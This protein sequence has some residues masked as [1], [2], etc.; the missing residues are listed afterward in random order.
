[1]TLQEADD[2]VAAC[3]WTPS[4]EEEGASFIVFAQRGRRFFL[5]SLD[6]R[7]VI[8][9]S[10][11]P[12]LD[13]PV[14][15][16]DAGDNQQYT[17]V[18]SVLA[19]VVILCCGQTRGLRCFFT[20]PPGDAGSFTQSI[21][22]TPASWSCARCVR[23]SVTPPTAG[24]AAGATSSLLSQPRLWEERFWCYCFLTA[25][26][27]VYCWTATFMF[28]ASWHPFFFS[29]LILF[30]SPGA[31]TPEGMPHVSS[32][33]MWNVRVNG[34]EVVSVLWVGSKSRAAMGPR[35]V[36]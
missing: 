1:M 24:A 23:L 10:S 32:L 26:S 11:L 29:S 34:R 16:E 27:S 9:H 21:Y 31:L 18:A 19:C 14:G 8:L 5:Y 30:G 4:E 25:V 3:N 33:T 36:Q 13:S 6:D 17:G 22:P 15:V 7:E 28:W 2:G 12:L 35:V 20:P